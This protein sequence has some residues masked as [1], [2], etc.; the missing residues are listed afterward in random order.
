MEAGRQRLSVMGFS[1][2]LS[3][4]MYCSIAAS[5]GINKTIVPTVTVVLGSCVFRIIRVY[6]IFPAAGTTTSLYLLYPVSWAITAAETVYFAIM[7]KKAV[8]S[9]RPAP[10][11]GEAGESAAQ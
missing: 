7:Y 9:I 3:A 10:H 11:D 2:A 5:R 4:V 6:L 8:K 1:Y